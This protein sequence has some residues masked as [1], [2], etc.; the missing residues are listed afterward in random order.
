MRLC[1]PC[2][3]GGALAPRAAAQSRHLGALL[4][5]PLGSSTMAASAPTVQEPMELSHTSD[6]LYSSSGNPVQEAAPGG[7]AA[8]WPACAARQ[9]LAE[10][11]QP[12]PCCFRKKRNLRHRCSADSSRQNSYTGADGGY[13]VNL[14]NSSGKGITWAVDAG[15]AGTYTAALAL[16]NAPV[17]KKRYD[18][19]GYWSMGYRL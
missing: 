3:S 17:P 5:G 6:R 1:V 13:Y 8:G 14:S 7:N 9:R 15:A 16:F 12:D 10:I 2:A 11:R 18:G 19:K 4:E